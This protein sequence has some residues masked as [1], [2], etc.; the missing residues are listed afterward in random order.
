MAAVRRVRNRH[1]GF[2]PVEDDA[3]LFWGEIADAGFHAEPVLAGHRLEDALV[4]GGHRR[5]PGVRG[6]GALG[7]RQVA[8]GNDQVGVDLHPHTQSR[9]VRAGA[10]GAVETEVPGRDLSETDSAHGTGEVL[11]VQPV[12]LAVDP[13]EKHAAAELQGLFDGVGEAAGAGGAPFGGRRLRD[14]AVHDDFDGV[15]AVLVELELLVEVADLAV[16]AN[17]HVTGAPG[18]LEH[19]LVLAFPVTDDGREEHDPLAGRKRQDGIDDLLHGLT[20][21]GASTVRAMR[22]ADAREQQTEVVVDL[23]DRGHGGPWIL[24]DAL[25]VDGDGGRQP[26]DVVDVG[27]FHLAE[28]LAGVGGEGLDITPLALGVNGIESERTLARARQARDDHQA[29]S[30]DFNVDVFEVVLSGASDDDGVQRHRLLRRS[31]GGAAGEAQ[32]R[33]QVTSV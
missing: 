19:V 26:L 11:R 3:E 10:V 7:E 24:A 6:D 27:L 23:G 29:V 15:P 13:D 22:P 32:R 1:R 28:E 20:L 9:A 31:R 18:I 33:G 2:V 25:L 17:A 5:G 14:Q 12:A 16:D 8:V 4:P 30:G 21:D